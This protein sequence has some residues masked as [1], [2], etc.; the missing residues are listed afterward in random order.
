MKFRPRVWSVSLLVATA[1]INK[2]WRK[3]YPSAIVISWY[4]KVKR[5]AGNL[6]IRE[7]KRQSRMQAA[8][9]VIHKLRL[10]R[11]SLVINKIYKINPERAIERIAVM[12]F[13]VIIPIPDRIK[14]PKK[15]KASRHRIVVI[16]DSI[17]L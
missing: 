10:R 17:F 9:S 2:R 11:S 3:E 13:K 7:A 12:A 15:I 8:A 16:I 4:Y 1:F 5:G 14:N 6:R